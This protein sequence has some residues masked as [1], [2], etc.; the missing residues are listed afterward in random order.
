MKLDAEWFRRPA[1]TP[2]F[3]GC[4]NPA[5]EMPDYYQMFLRNVYA[6]ALN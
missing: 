5:L 6:E 1:G 3:L 2:L 4:K